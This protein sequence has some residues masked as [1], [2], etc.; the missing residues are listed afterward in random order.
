M[1]KLGLY[2]HKAKQLVDRPSPG[3][4]IPPRSGPSQASR[5]G[6]RGRDGKGHKISL[7]IGFSYPGIVKQRA[8]I[9]T[10]R[11]GRSIPFAS[12]ERL[13]RHIHDVGHNRDPLQGEPVKQPLRHCHEG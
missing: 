8:D 2:R 11:Q 9:P 5:K 4:S 3:N 12:V 6:S 7:K 13:Q 10:S 1:G